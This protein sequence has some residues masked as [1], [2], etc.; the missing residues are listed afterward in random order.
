LICGFVFYGWGLG[1]YGS[2]ERLEQLFLV[3]SVWSFQLIFSTL[4]MNHFLFGPFE[5]LWRTMTYSKVQSIKIKPEVL[6]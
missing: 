1:L 2:F 3:L 4:W 5:W 6:T